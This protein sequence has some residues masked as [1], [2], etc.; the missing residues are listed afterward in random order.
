MQNDDAAITET[1]EAVLSENPS[2]VE[3]YNAGKEKAF[4]FL[5][6][7]TMKKLGGSGN[8]AIVKKVLKE[9]LDSAVE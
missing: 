9:L 3:D 2:A 5:M 4:G 8:P 7:Q 1:I 6:G